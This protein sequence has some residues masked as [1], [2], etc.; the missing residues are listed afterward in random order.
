MTDDEVNT[1]ARELVKKGVLE[2]EFR[3]Q[4]NEAGERSGYGRSPAEAREDIA[5]MMEG[6]VPSRFAALK[7][8]P[9]A[10]GVK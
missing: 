10:P 3:A 1:V 2:G 7:R 8:P 6:K 5:E 4:F 9:P